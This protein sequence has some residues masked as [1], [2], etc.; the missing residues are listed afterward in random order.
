MYILFYRNCQNKQR[1]FFFAL[2]F[3]QALLMRRNKEVLMKDF[4]KIILHKMFFLIS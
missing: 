3:G 1:S 2:L 4:F